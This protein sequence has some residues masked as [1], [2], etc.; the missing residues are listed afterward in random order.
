MHYY[1]WGFFGMHMLWWVFWLC[2][3]VVFFGLLTPVP[4][5]RARR[6]R[7]TPLEVLQRRYANGEI[8]TV[9]YQER[10]AILEADRA[11]TQSPTEWQQPNPQGH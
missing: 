10:K 5:G 11:A 3:L 4:R 2:M 6:Q 7:Q 1:G 9:E 8:T